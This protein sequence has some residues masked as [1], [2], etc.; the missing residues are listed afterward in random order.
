MSTILHGL[1]CALPPLRLQVITPAPGWTNAKQIL[2]AQGPEAM[3]A[4]VKA[5]KKVLL[6]DTTMRDAHQ[7]HLATRVRTEDLVKSAVVANEVRVCVV[8]GGRRG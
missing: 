8:G 3:V 4:W 5:Q 7:S 2:D 1:S 6:T